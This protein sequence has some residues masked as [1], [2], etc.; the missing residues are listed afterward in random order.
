MTS[1]SAISGFGRCTFDQ[2][3]AGR[4]HE[5]SMTEHTYLNALDIDSGVQ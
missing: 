1:I 4:Q 2:K 5:V 3:A